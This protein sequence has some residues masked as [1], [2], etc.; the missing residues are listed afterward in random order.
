MAAATSEAQISKDLTILF[1]LTSRPS[2]YEIEDQTATGS[3]NRE[4]T[5]IVTLFP[6]N[7]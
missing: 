6:G 1:G 2:L 7:C 4:Y 3:K 5:D